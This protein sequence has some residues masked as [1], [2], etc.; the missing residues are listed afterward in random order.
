MPLRHHARGARPLST[1]D[2]HGHLDPFGR[3]V[4]HLAAACRAPR[5]AV[6]R[7]PPLLGLA[8]RPSS[9]ELRIELHRDVPRSDLRSRPRRRCRRR[10]WSRPSSRGLRF[11]GSVPST[12]ISSRHRRGRR[13]GLVARF[14]TRRPRRHRV[15]DPVAARL[16]RFFADESCGKCTPCREA[17]HGSTRSC[18]GSCTDTDGSKTSPS[19][20]T[21][22]A[23][24]DPEPPSARSARLRSPR[25]LDADALGDH[26]LAHIHLAGCPWRGRPAPCSV[27]R[28][29]S[30]PSAR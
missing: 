13:R 5:S 16:V 3:S 17:R 8:S 29:A 1:A 22:A 9:R 15:P 6:D 14:W 23:A 19:S 21:S 30:G 12:S 26:Y 7:D 25:S 4:A 28:M 20:R 2:A 10:S 24:W 27:S 18:T 11:R